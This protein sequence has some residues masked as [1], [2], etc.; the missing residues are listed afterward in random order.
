[1]SGP[2]T[3]PSCGQ[4]RCA[5]TARRPASRARGTSA[6]TPSARPAST[7]SP[8]SHPIV[9]TCR[10]A[11]PSRGGP[12]DDRRRRRDA[13]RAR[14]RD[15]PAQRQRL[16]HRLLRPLHHLQL[17]RP[18][19]ATSTAAAGR[20]STPSPADRHEGECSLMA[21]P[22]CDSTPTS[23]RTTRSS[24]SSS[25]A[26]APKA[27]VLYISAMVWSGGAGQ[28]RHAS[29]ARPGHQP[30]QPE[31]SPTSSSTCASGAPSRGGGT[32]FPHVGPPPEPAIAREVRAT[33][34]AMGGRKGNC[35][36]WH[37]PD[38]GCWR[39]LRASA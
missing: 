5:A 8:G 27:F 12:P 35:V 29:R 39:H 14:D 22:G 25:T 4:S 9:S 38:C 30:R 28:D 15:A 23:G 3:C 11:D 10:R 1:M 32:R 34:K 31:S 19:C 17:E 16:L 33:L 24:S 13:P 2:L 7:A 18:T 37:G 21:P 6:S 26:T 36:R 20:S